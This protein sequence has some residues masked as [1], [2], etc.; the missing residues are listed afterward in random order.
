MAFAAVAGVALWST[1]AVLS[2]VP[3]PD[4]PVPAGPALPFDQTGDAGSLQLH[5]LEP[6]LTLSPRSSPEG[7]DWGS[8]LEVD[9][10]SDVGRGPKGLVRHT[11]VLPLRKGSR[12]DRV[13]WTSLDVIVDGET[14]ERSGRGG[15]TA[16]SLSWTVAEGAILLHAPTPL[17]PAQVGL[18]MR[19]YEKRL[20]QLERDQFEGTDAEFV[21]FTHSIDDRTRQGLMLPA[22]AVAEYDVTLPEGAWFESWLAMVP[23]PMLG[24]ESTGA[25]A[26]LSVIVDGKTTEVSR[27][28][29]SPEP[30]MLS[31]LSSSGG[32]DLWTADLS[33]YAGKPLT[34][35]LET[36][37]GSDPSYDYVFV[38]A[39]VVS[40]KPSK[41]V[42]RV[43]VLA[44]DTLR[45][46][47]LNTY[48]Y[49]RE[50]LTPE[51]DAFAAK[52]TVFEK[53]WSPAPRTRPSFR[54]ATTGRDPLS[55]VGATNIGEVFRDH[56]FATAGIVSNVHLNPR[57]DF[58]Q[59]F[60]DWWLDPLAKADD[61]VDRALSWLK[62]NEHR[63]SYL[64][65][66]IMDPHL[67]YIAPE[68]FHSAW[69]KEL[70]PTLPQEFNRWMVVNWERSGELTD[71]RKEHIES[72]YDAEIA[73]T[74]SQ[75]G[76]LMDGI[77][78]MGDNSLVMFHTDHGEE[79]WEHDGFEHNHTLYDEVV[80][81]ALVVKPPPGEPALARSTEPVWLADMAP[82]LFD[83]VGFENVPE[84]DGRSLRP[85]VSKA[86]EGHWKRALPV[87]GLMYDKERWGV[88][89]DGKKYIVQTTLGREE[90]YDLEAD[91]GE[92]KNLSARSNLPELQAALGRAHGMQV[93]P[94]WRIQLL[95]MRPDSLTM[96]LPKKAVA[97]GIFDPEADLVHRANQ[98]WGEVPR[99]TP[100]DVGTV[101]LSEDGR[102]LT[103]TK[104]P[105]P[106]GYLWVMFEEPTDVDVV[107][108]SEGEELGRLKGNRRRWIAKGNNLFFFPGP[109]FQ[110][111]IGEVERMGLLGNAE[112]NETC[113][114]CELGYLH[115][116]A[117]DDC[118]GGG[119]ADESDGP[120]E[121]EVDSEAAE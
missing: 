104:G 115:G 83:Y 89:Y 12:P 62:H 92:Q 116:D 67:L 37:P 17:K 19:G 41:P 25:E 107:L 35:R 88:V 61:Q 7:T 52:G 30:S 26:V 33:K 111:P 6:R 93:G 91:P 32:F 5:Q 55:A 76:R 18:K 119:E 81:A 84:T 82:T 2:E 68:P 9:A 54:T 4:F 24:R 71:K 98:A 46:D 15:P 120:D 110:T 70:D 31:T 59:G 113:Q 87:S 64:F 8:A 39:P 66:H 78:A 48:G 100:A 79:F 3:R 86:D 94:G 27:R 56:G 51:I 97:A 57:F 20:A 50:G 53:A 109:V 96:K 28:V 14:V 47:H 95:Q 80:R 105:R 10:F 23:S 58:H 73:W 38:G 60:D 112:D 74:S 11:I 103:L 29:I 85:L 21:P 22:P 45:P 1:L 90:V 16:Q 65:L 72:L 108:S 102:S 114:L 63:D 77:D 118:G 106:R 99:Y 44:I 69:A 40:G 13:A 75:V 49:E 36:R 101:E 117:C 42:R 121:G 34:L 43:V